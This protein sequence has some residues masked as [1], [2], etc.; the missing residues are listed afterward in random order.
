M[1]VLREQ[2]KDLLNV[3]LE[4]TDDRVELDHYLENIL[5]LTDDLVQGFDH[6]CRL[7]DGAFLILVGGSSFHLL[8]KREVL[9]HLF[10]LI[11]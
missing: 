9:F 3:T 7:H 4:G 10:I 11:S 8:G 6:G 2:I 1:S 5:V